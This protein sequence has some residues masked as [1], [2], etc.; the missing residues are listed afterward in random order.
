MM[1]IFV[2]FSTSDKR[3]HKI[4]FGKPEGKGPFERWE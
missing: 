1:R 2:G 3:W 4:L